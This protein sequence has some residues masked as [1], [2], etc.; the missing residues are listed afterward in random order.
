GRPADCLPHHNEDRR[1]QAPLTRGLPWELTQ[2]GRATVPATIQESLLDGGRVLADE[3]PQVLVETGVVV[4]MP[5]GSGRHGM[6]TIARA[7]RPDSRRC[8]VSW[9]Y[10]EGSH[11]SW[12]AADGCR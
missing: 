2:A 1:Q 9:L 4:E 10:D 7:R 3:E 11:L 12:E 5:A 8:W 6:L